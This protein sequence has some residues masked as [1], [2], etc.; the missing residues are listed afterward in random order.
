M[1]F[2]VVFLIL[3]SKNSLQPEKYSLKKIRP[4]EISCLLV[5]FLLPLPVDQLELNLIFRF[6]EVY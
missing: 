6:N 2:A 5:L 1:K 4:K 3:K